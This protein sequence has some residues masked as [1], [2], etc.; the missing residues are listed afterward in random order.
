MSGK[1]T[2]DGP[3]RVAKALAAEREEL[4]SER[5]GRIACYVDESG[6]GRPLVLV[7]SINAAPS[8]F[9][10][11][12]LFEHYRGKRP[13]YAPD[14]PGFGASQRGERAYTPELYVDALCDLLERRVGQPADLVALSLSAEFAAAAALRQPDRV[15]SLAL[16]SPTGLGRREVPGPD[17]GKRM[18]RFFGLPVL[19]DALFKLI[20]SKPSLRYFLGLNFSGKPPE[21]MVAYAY[22]TSHQP[23][24]TFAPWAFLSFG[25][26]TRDALSRLYEPLEL[27]V[28]VLFDED[29]NV[30]FE[31][32]AEIER[33]RANW[34]SVRIQPSRGLPQ[35][36][37]PGPTS[38]ALEHFWR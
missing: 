3:A 37:Q 11:K 4:H 20:T 21:E 29:P 38:D 15:A 27:P 18:R 13:V 5:A 17:T 10:M 36:E 12:P 16:I 32:L 28:L 25:L 9:E 33:T 24:A 30:S 19:P 22:E 26:F 1:S 14:L 34:R 23:G 7:H 31:R 6:S 8:A 2:Q 35:W